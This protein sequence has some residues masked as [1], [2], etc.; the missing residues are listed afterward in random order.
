MGLG[1][2]IDLG[3]GGE[4]LAGVEDYGLGGAAG[5]GLA[6]DSPNG[7]G[8]AEDFGWTGDIGF[9]PRFCMGCF[10]SS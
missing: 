10:S 4:G 1:L 8:G 9:G 2:G 6:G 7:F 3:V 5:Y